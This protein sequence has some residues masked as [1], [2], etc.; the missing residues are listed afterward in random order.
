[1]IRA[2]RPSDHADPISNLNPDGVTFVDYLEAPNG[3]FTMLRNSIREIYDA[4]DTG[5][6]IV[7]IQKKTSS[8]YG[9]GGEGTL[10][11]A[12]LA[13]NLDKLLV[14]DRGKPEV[15]SACKIVKSK[16]PCEGQSN[17]EGKETH[18]LIENTKITQ[19]G[20]WQ[21]VNFEQRNDLVNGYRRR[22]GERK[23]SSCPTFEI[24]S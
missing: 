1:M 11:K 22:C 9:V 7:A 3:D 12:R 13:L 8:E 19:M 4:L 2:E 14:P 21:H 10:E 24:P 17:P 20:P 18:L 16:M 23:D 6:A 15:I 5:V